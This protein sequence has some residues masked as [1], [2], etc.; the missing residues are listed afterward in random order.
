MKVII[1]S[2]PQTRATALAGSNGRPR[3]QLRD[4]AD[5]PVPV[6]AGA[7]D[8]DVQV[9]VEATA[10]V[11]ELAQEQQVGRR[12]GADEHADRCEVVAVRERVVNRGPQRRQPDSA[13]H[14]HEVATARF[15][16]RPGRA[17][18]PA[19]ADDRAGR[20]RTRAC[21]TAPTSRIVWR[22]APAESGEALVEIGTSPTPNAY[23]MLNWPGAGT[24]GS[25]SGSSMSVQVSAVSG[26][27]ENEAVGLRA[28]SRRARPAQLSLSLP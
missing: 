11:L 18:R 2:G 7:V 9:D 8:R 27:R 23:S 14:D 13:G 3:D 4:D 15:L 28:S 21:E 17:E 26:A 20:G 24:T 10:P 25:A 12:P 6:L 22:S 5:A 19:D 1:S 16:E